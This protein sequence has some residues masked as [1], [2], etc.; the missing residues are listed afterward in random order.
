VRSKPR[1]HPE[2][3]CQCTRAQQSP[4]RPAAWPSLLRR[5]IGVAV[6]AERRH[7]GE[8]PAA[9]AGVATASATAVSRVAGVTRCGAQLGVVTGASV[10]G[11]WAQHWLPAAPTLSPPLAVR[12]LGEHGAD[13]AEV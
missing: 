7:D 8:R 6:H 13:A 4:R 2:P 10:G 12:R 5:P 1:C 9:L 3:C 11:P